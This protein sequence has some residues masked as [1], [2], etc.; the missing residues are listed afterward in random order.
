[1]GPL[2]LKANLRQDQLDR[3]SG[4]FLLLDNSDRFGSCA[5]RFDAAARRPTGSRRSLMCLRLW[6]LRAAGLRVRALLCSPPEM[7]DRVT[8]ARLNLWIWGCFSTV[9]LRFFLP[10]R[11]AL[12]FLMLFN[13]L[14]F[15]SKLMLATSNFSTL[16]AKLN[17]LL[18]FLSY[19]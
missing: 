7:E 9:S 1:M 17:E 11:E 18:L 10:Q 16:C 12:S 13:L 4:R 2:H 14:V 8:N 15:V 6:G 5:S 19:L 3:L